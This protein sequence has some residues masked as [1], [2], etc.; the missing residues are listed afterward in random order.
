MAFETLNARVAA[1]R[2][3]GAA[4]LIV[5]VHIP[6]TAGSTLRHQLV[7]HIPIFRVDPVES[8]VDYYA[9][10]GSR[11]SE[12][13]P[14]V[15]RQSAAMF[16]SGHYRFRDARTVL[17]PVKF[18][19][20][21]IA[22]LRDPVRRFLSDYF[23]S[24]SDANLTHKAMRERYPTVESYMRAGGQLN[25]Q[26]EYMRPFEGASVGDTVDALCAE[27]GLVGITENYESHADYLFQA[28]DIPRKPDQKLNV[29][30]EQEA[31]NDAC[32]RYQDMLSTAQEYEVDLYDAM[33]KRTDWIV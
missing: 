26:L 31:I 1:I 17:A 8:F 21:M 29:G 33:R 18:Q 20:L 28:F 27:M 32:L 9:D 10:L 24:I 25:K 5:N 23:Y 12:V 30:K 13:I 19:T 6:K 16:A 4:P 3:S 2:S 14:L 7:R 11:L 15:R 22:F